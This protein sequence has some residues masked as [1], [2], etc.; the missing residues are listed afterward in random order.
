MS[1]VA[2][3]LSFYRRI[4]LQ[5]FWLC[6]EFHHEAWEESGRVYGY[7]EL[8]D[9]LVDMGET[10]SPNRVASLAGLADIR[11]QIGYK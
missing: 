7:R 6:R 1:Q 2:S 3:Y 9:E 4:V 8:H 10:I 11:A 5:Y